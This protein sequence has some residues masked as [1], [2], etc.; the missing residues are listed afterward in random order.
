MIIQAKKTEENLYFTYGK[1]EEY[2][3]EKLK[4]MA[5]NIFPVLCESWKCNDITF[6]FIHDKREAEIFRLWS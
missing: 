6:R 2:D 1:V 4:D 5:E 3:I